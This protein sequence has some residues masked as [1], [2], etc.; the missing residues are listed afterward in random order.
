MES[1][2]SD[3]NEPPCSPKGRVVFKPVSYFCIQR[4]LGVMKGITRKVAVATDLSLEA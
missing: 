3:L 2:L 1:K 4:A